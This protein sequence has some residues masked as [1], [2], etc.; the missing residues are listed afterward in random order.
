[1]GSNSRSILQFALGICS[2]HLSFVSCVGDTT[3]WFLVYVVW[4]LTSVLSNFRKT[5]YLPHFFVCS[6]RE[7]NPG[8][9]GDRLECWPLHHR[10]LWVD[11]NILKF[12]TP[13]KCPYWGHVFGSENFE[14]F[15]PHMGFPPEL[16]VRKSSFFSNKSH[17]WCLVVRLS[18]ER[19]VYIN[20]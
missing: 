17:R 19:S 7:W 20:V 15:W 1:M 12:F 9:T 6:S 8:L 4:N 18:A 14:K 11:R 10:S 16:F 3:C 13:L 5:F 2:L